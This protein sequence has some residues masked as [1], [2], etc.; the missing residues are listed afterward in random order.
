MRPIS[1][2]ELERMRQTAASPLPDTCT[3]QTRTQSVDALGGISYSYANTYT[4]VTCRL[5][6]GQPGSETVRNSAV[7]AESGWTLT[8]AYDQAIGVTDRVIHAGLTYEVAGVVDNRS[9]KTERQAHLVRV[10]NG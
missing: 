7:Q 9:Y 2:G 5:D 10:D 4:G 8:V 1:P 6:A 3:I